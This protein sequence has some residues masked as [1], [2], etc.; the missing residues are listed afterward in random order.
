MASTSKTHAATTS[1][2]HENG[3]KDGK[4]DQKRP[5]KITV[6]G[7]KTVGK[8]WLSP[9]TTLLS[10]YHMTSSLVM[11]DSIIWN[12]TMTTAKWEQFGAPVFDNYEAKVLCDN[13]AVDV[14]VWYGLSSCHLIHIMSPCLYYHFI[15]ESDSIHS[16]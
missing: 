13:K 5:L 2:S 7:D 11:V 14:S 1:N 3:D 12:Y 15:S 10:P 16:A 9:L 4:I 6:V 8:T